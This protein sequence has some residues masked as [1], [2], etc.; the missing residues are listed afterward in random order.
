MSAILVSARVRMSA[1]I[2]RRDRRSEQL[3][4][5]CEREPKL[6]NPPDESETARSVRWK[7][8]VTGCRAWGFRQQASSLIETNGFQIDPSLLGEVSDCQ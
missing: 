6:L 3:P 7:Q 5:L 1:V 2:V 4:D 8:T